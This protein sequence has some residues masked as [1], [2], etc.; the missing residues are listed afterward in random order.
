MIATDFIFRFLERDFAAAGTGAL[1]A[2]ACAIIGSFLVLRRMSLMGDAI[3]HA[4][5]PGIVAAFVVTATLDALPVFIGAVIVGVVT[6]LL[7][8]TVHR[9]GRVESGASMGVVFTFLFA[10]GVIWLEQIGGRHIH[11]DAD[12]VLYGNM[13]NV[14]WPAAPNSFG[15]MFTFDALASLPRQIKTLALVLVLNAIF[16]TLFFKELRIT[17]FDPE[18]AASQGISPAI[19]HYLLMT[20]VAIT[21]VASFE[22]VGS[23]LVVAV[24]IVPGMIARLLNDRLAIMVILSAIIALIAAS[25]GYAGAAAMSIDST[26]SV[27]IA[28]GA[29]LLAAA[30]FSP[31]Y[32]WVSRAVRRLRMSVGILREDMLGILY[33]AREVSPDDLPRAAHLV[34]A[35]G[36]GVAARLALRSIVRLGQASLEGD[37][38]RL[39]G[40]GERQAAR[41]IRSHR[42]WESYLVNRLGLRGDHVHDTAMRL[43]HV[44]DEPMRRRLAEIARDGDVDPHGRAIPDER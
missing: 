5:L 19:M 36:G 42:L 2:V 41:V 6:A 16:V 25:G 32:G 18:L 24:L 9:F 10:I 35:V 28:L 43:E 4:V 37:G 39:T 17:S 14:I 26:G 27:G 34:E 23:I 44:T 38:L 40:A 31:K 8:E 29:L 22:A 13:Q 30:L 12:C 7:T 11:L 15:E 20:M 33:R 1:A 3:S 21:T